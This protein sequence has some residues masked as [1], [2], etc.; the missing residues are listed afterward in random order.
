[1]APNSDT[2]SP[3]KDGKTII[4]RNK[5]PQLLDLESL[6]LP[7]DPTP[8]NLPTTAETLRNIFQDDTLSPEEQN[9]FAESILMII[10]Q[11]PSNPSP[12][13]HEGYEEIGFALNKELRR[14]H[15]AWV[16]KIMAG[17]KAGDIQGDNATSI[18]YEESIPSEIHSTSGSSSS[19]CQNRFMIWEQVE[20]E[21]E[22]AWQQNLN[23]DVLI[24]HFALFKL[25]F[26]ER[27]RRCSDQDKTSL[28]HLLSDHQIAWLTKPLP[29]TS[30]IKIL[31][32]EQVWIVIWS[33]TK[34]ARLLLRNGGG[35]IEDN[36]RLDEYVSIMLAVWWLVRG[37]PFEYIN[38]AQSGDGPEA[39]LTAEGFVVSKGAWAGR[40]MRE[41]LGGFMDEAHQLDRTGKDAEKTMECGEVTHFIDPGVPVNRE[42]LVAGIIEEALMNITRGTGRGSKHAEGR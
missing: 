25:H 20:I 2:P 14:I 26:M 11:Q 1:M 8:T 37:D 34:F 31:N 5:L 18:D 9:S 39:Y 24:E 30:N 17:Y 36:T 10:R 27:T 40:M 6:Q 16:D 23:R 13:S 22:I 21:A 29:Q 3:A 38:R 33:V 32:M 15:S 28:Q 35:A 4:R 7:D 41:K 19:S 12:Y 42:E